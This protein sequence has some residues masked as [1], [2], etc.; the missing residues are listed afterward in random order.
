MPEF[1]GSLLTL[2]GIAGGA[3]VGFK[4]AE[5]HVVETSPASDE[6]KMGY[7]PE[8]EPSGGK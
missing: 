8:P 4:I 2:M 6:H 7:A 1:D 5:T 3:Y